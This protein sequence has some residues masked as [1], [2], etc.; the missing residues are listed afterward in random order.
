MS[1][2]YI[3]ITEAAEYLGISTEFGQ[4]DHGRR[5]QGLPHRQ[6]RT[7]PH[8][9]GRPGR[10]RREA[11]AADRP[12]LERFLGQ[13][14]QAHQQQPRAGSLDRSSAE[15]T[16]STRRTTASAHAVTATGDHTPDGVG[17]CHAPTWVNIPGELSRDTG[18]CKCREFD[19]DVKR[20]RRKPRKYQG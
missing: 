13:A 19:E 2:R 18:P 8:D 6:L 20:R 12:V 16:P 4:P 10:D 14:P 15:S 11:H 1:R 9:Q 5:D 3:S 7:P 17:P